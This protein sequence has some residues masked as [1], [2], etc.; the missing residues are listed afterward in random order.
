VAALTSFEVPPGRRCRRNAGMNLADLLR[1]WIELL[2]SRDDV[3]V[4]RPLSVGAPASPVLAD[5]PD[6][7]RAFAERA[8]SMSFAYRTNDETCWGGLELSLE[9]LREDA[10]LVVD[11]AEVDPE[12]MFAL[13]FDAE[14]TGQSAWLVVGEPPFVVWDV[15]AV[16][17]FGSL[18]EYLTEGARRGFCSEPSW[19]RR[20]GASRLARHS[21]PT[22]TPIEAIRAALLARGAG[23]ADAA[24]L[25]EW[26]GADAA[27]LVPRPGGPEAVV[28]E[29]AD[30]F[31]SEL[32]R[33][34]VVHAR[35]SDPFDVRFK[36]S[37]EDE[38]MRR[39]EHALAALGH[40]MQLE[41]LGSSA[42]VENAP[43][44]WGSFNVGRF[45]IERDASLPAAKPRAMLF[46][47]GDL[48]GLSAAARERFGSLGAWLIRGEAV[49]RSTI[50]DRIPEP[51]VSGSELDE[52]MALLGA[53]A[54][55]PEG[56]V[57]G[58]VGSTPSMD[59]GFHAGAS[60][61]QVRASFEA[62][63]FEI[64]DARS[65]GERWPTSI[66]LG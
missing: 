65:A 52:V 61:E 46:P 57:R 11:G 14:G 51:A 19:Q 40:P 35:T 23:L 43:G 34:G 50:L 58:L 33:F 49:P 28:D 5:Y 18:T 26:L 16:A 36:V 54:R 44:A 7:A 13:E 2:S 32:A 22:S 6:D 41:S 29:E 24:A 9:G 8:A 21:L 63:G 37:G 55:D 39:L 47:V 62:D 15:E 38:N 45:W 42:L 64:V 59:F 60:F 27:L 10:S 3:V 53:A 48:V 56:I 20:D 25:I 17:R 4:R 12:K 30:R 31:A 66:A 1:V